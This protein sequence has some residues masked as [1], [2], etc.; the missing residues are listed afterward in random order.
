MLIT[1]LITAALCFGGFAAYVKITD[2][3]LVDRARYEEVAEAY[4]KYS[5]FF[6]MQSLI[7]GQ[8][9]YDYDGDS[10]RLAQVLETA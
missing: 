10:R 3:V 7:E 8:Y 5:K 6:D 1:V 2:K 4:V 9:L